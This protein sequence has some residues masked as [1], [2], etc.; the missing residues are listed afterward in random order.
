MTKGLFTWTQDSKLINHCPGLSVASRT[1][2]DLLFRSPGG[3]SI[4]IYTGRAVFHGII[5]Q[6]VS[7]FSKWFLSFLNHLRLLPGAE[8]KINCS[9]SEALLFVWLRACSHEPRTVN[10]SIIAPGQ[11]LPLVHMMICCP[12]ARGALPYESI[13]DVPFFHGIIFQHK[14]LNG[15][16]KLIRNSETGYE[17][18]FKNKRLLFSRTIGY[19]FT[20]YTPIVL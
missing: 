19:C 12:G 8:A 1:H 2:D 15:V 17:Y 6:Y 20:H 10:S 11:V 3:T 14:F 16:W 5:F 9:Y 13:Q 4:W 18:L 7:N